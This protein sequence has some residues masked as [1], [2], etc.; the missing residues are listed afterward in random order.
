MFF[1]AKKTELVIAKSKSSVRFF[2]LYAGQLIFV[3]L[4]LAQFV[5]SSR[6]D[7]EGGNCSEKLYSFYVFVFLEYKVHAYNRNGLCAVGFMDD[8]YPVRS[9][10]SVLNKV[11]PC[12]SSIANKTLT[13]SLRKICLFEQILHFSLLCQ[14]NHL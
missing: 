6:E 5:F 4:F 11:N 9:A 14:Y 2:D 10:F 12:S 3:A 1:Y 13:F 7:L 8:H